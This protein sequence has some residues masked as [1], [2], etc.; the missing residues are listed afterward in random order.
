LINSYKIAQKTG[1][2][3]LFNN[4]EFVGIILNQF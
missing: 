4:K 2:I 3:Y 1:D